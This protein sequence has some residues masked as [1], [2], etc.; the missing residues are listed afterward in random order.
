MGVQE[1]GQSSLNGEIKRGF[2]D[3]KIFRMNFKQWIEFQEGE[4]QGRI[5]WQK[6]IA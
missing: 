1:A 5:F 2:V 3:E 4:M 6:K